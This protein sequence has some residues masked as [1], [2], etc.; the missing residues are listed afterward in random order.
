MIENATTFNTL[1]RKNKP[2]WKNWTRKEKLYKFVQAIQGGGKKVPYVFMLNRN[3][4]KLY[5]GGIGKYNP[6]LWESGFRYVKDIGFISKYVQVC[7][8]K[9]ST[10]RSMSSCLK[11]PLHGKN[12]LGSRSRIAL[13]VGHFNLKLEIIFF[14][15]S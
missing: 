13:T 6:F 8:N 7:E 1:A 14:Y 4:N 2:L 10:W 5:S 15:D 12:W 11:T 3:F 9:D